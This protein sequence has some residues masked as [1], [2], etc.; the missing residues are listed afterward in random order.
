MLNHIFR[1]SVSQFRVSTQQTHDNRKKEQTEQTASKYK[2]IKGH[3]K[4]TKEIDLRFRFTPIW[5]RFRRLIW[6]PSSPIT[7]CLPFLHV[8][9]YR[10]RARQNQQEKH[11]VLWIFVTQDHL[12][13]VKSK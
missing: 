13:S 7:I 8:D 5:R 9:N 11:C 4:I 10:I 2:Q 3:N 12:H 1:E 6:F